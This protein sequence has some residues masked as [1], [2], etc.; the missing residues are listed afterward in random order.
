MRGEDGRVGCGGF[1]G[2]VGGSLSVVGVES[3]HLPDKTIK[4][5]I[6]SKPHIYDFTVGCNRKCG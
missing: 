4:K 5:R 1:V 3:E 6:F 2:W